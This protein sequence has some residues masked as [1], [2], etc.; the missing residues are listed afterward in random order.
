MAP[1]RASPPTAAAGTRAALPSPVGP[2]M[3]PPLAG[4][5][6]E[7]LATEAPSTI[8]ATATAT[9]RSCPKR[10]V[11]PRLPRG[12]AWFRW[13]RRSGAGARWEATAKDRRPPRTWRAAVTLRVWSVEAVSGPRLLGRRS[14]PMTR[15]TPT[16]AFSNTVSWRMDGPGAGWGARDGGIGPFLGRGMELGL[17]LRG[18]RPLHGLTTSGR[19]YHGGCGSDKPVTGRDSVATGG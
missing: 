2:P 18:R 6:A 17:S 5:P 13:R 15:W 4:P 12:A 16:D 9:I 10:A 8:V 14:R 7:M 1:L 11:S 3:G 19:R